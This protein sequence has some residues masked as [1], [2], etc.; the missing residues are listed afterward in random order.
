MPHAAARGRQ[1]VLPGNLTGLLGVL[2]GGGGMEA[3]QDA[4]YRL[5]SGGNL[6]RR[7]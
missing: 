5:G 1:P 2:L 6:A 4:V 3:D 7:R